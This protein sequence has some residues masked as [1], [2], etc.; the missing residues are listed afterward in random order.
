MQNGIASEVTIIY[1]IGL[2]L[3]LFG[4]IG[5]LVGGE[6]DRPGAGFLLGLF[7]GPI[8]LIIAILLP[9][10]GGR[11]PDCKGGYITGAK[12]CRFCGRE[13]RL[14]K[15]VR[16]ILSKMMDSGRYSVYE[17][18]IE[19]TQKVKLELETEEDTI[20]ESYPR[21]WSA[22]KI[23]EAFSQKVKKQ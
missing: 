12:V 7:L 21:S 13:F 10:G 6:K 15:R 5:M 11:C 1:G 17:E 20:S 18:T 19:G 14:I 8:G 16:S 23:V 2:A 22:D 3:L 9:Y 4:I